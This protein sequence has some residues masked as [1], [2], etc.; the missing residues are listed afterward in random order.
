MISADIKELKNLFEDTGRFQIYLNHAQEISSDC[1]YRDEVS[2]DLDYLNRSLKSVLLQLEKVAIDEAFHKSVKNVLGLVKSYDEFKGKFLNTKDSII[3]E[4]IQLAYKLE[5]SVRL[6][7][8]SDYRQ[9]TTDLAVA[10][11]NVSS[12]IIGAHLNAY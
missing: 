5:K 10:A 2:R 6:R 3:E 8:Y 1:S 4:N 11:T 12:K 7:L 9:Q